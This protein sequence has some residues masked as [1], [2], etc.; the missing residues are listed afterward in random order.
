MTHAAECHLYRC[1]RGRT[2]GKQREKQQLAALEADRNVQIEQNNVARA[3]EQQAQ[4]D[5][6]NFVKEQTRLRHAHAYAKHK[7]KLQRD[8]EFHQTNKE[9]ACSTREE[10]RRVK[11]E[12]DA[13]GQLE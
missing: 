3:K 10:N 13:L 5:Y 12:A 2:L 9:M 1:S 7:Q 11:S 6:E 4:R 8:W